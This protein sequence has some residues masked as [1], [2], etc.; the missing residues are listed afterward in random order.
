M[1]YGDSYHPKV[2]SDLKKIDISA[3]REIH[4]VHIDKILSN[5]H[6]SELLFATLPRL[7]HGV[8]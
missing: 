8:F 1:S 7:I 6:S 2:K 4:A 3:A 5:P